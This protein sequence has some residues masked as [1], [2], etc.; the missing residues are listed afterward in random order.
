MMSRSGASFLAAALLA[1][2]ASEP[3]PRPGS[4]GPTHPEVDAVFADLDRDD[5]PGAA[6]GVLLN[7]AL[8]HRA[9]YGIANMDYGI[10]ITPETVFDIASISKQFGAMAALL[11]EEEGRLDLDADV[12]SYVP[13]IPDFGRVITP[14]HLIHHTSGI[15]DWPQS[16]ILG[17]VMYTDVISFDQILRMLY[18][19][20]DLDFDPG[21]EYSYSNTGYNLLAR[22]IEV[23][24]G[25]SFRAVTEERIFDPLGMDD[26]HF[27][28]DHLEIVPDRAES[29]APD[30]QQGYRRA[31]NQLT[32]LAS[33]SLNTT[34]DDFLLWMEN[35]DSGEVGGVAVLERMMERGRLNDGEEISYAYGLSTDSYRGLATVGHGGGWAGFR[36]NFVRFPDH[37]LSV[38]VFCNVSN[39]DPAG[40]ARRVAEVFLD[41]RMTSPEDGD[42][43]ETDAPR[44]PATLPLAAL[45][46]Y[47]GSYRSPELDST[48]DVLIEDGAL[49]VRNWRI[50]DVTL[51]PTGEDEF[52][53][54]QW[55]LSQVRFRRDEEGRVDGLLVTGGRIRN[56]R[57]ERVQ[58]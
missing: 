18:R 23:Q 8:V 15:R 46:A 21:S 53:G 52:A 58:F 27:S 25:R 14:R 54:D 29:Y 41:D 6:V 12:R 57:F 24:S 2:C 31:I 9:G 42:G 13:E 49:V 17:G 3:Q 33:S 22:I 26:T 20:E 5:A 16:M 30:D 11:L 4:E 43:D 36:T 35:Y 19:Q 1:A 56:V 10:P 51:T 39:C 37:D 40:R 34:L 28:D 44:P 48:Y 50:E 32:A 55:W 45:R 7:G 38:V 47:E